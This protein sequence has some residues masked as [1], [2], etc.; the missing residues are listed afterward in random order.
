MTNE[1]SWAQEELGHAELGDKRLTKRLVRLAE[2]LERQPFA[3]IPQACESWADTQAAYDF[4]SNEQVEAQAMVAAHRKATVARMADQSVVLAIQDT[5]LLNYTTHHATQGLGPIGIEAQQQQG[6]VMHATLAVTPEGTPLGLLAGQMWTREAGEYARKAQRKQRPIE[7][8]ESLKW[9]TAL[10]HSVAD[11]PQEVQ[12]VTVCDREADIYEFFTLAREL[13]AP[14]VVRAAQDRQV[15]GPMARL[16]ATVYARPSVGSLHVTMPARQD[17]PAR[18]ACLSVRFAKVILI[19]PQRPKQAGRREL[20]RLRLWAV[21]AA[22]ISPPPGVTPIYWLLLTNVPVRNF[23]E[24]TQRLDWYAQ[25]WKIEVFF[26]VLE[27]GCRVEHRRLRSVQ[28]LQRCLA[29]YAIVAARLQRLTF[30]ARQQPEASC[31]AVL[32]TAEWQTLYCYL[33]HTTLL[34]PQLP[35]LRQAMRWIAQL[36]GF[37]DR[38]G[39]GEPGIRTVWRGWQRLQD[40]VA[41]WLL[42]HPHTCE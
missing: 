21:L 42:L 20:P 14:L 17:Q 37:L 19:P 10:R 34:P 18:E 27:N 30:L 41:L 9:L 7:E 23:T 3:S 33:H 35:T 31:L 2:Q 32:S 36:G 16:Q 12:L 25:R 4:F 6:V 24:A 13:H 1:T 39:D 8:K 40:M 11:V 26:D 15:E 29:L 38:K 5:V 22:E 28:R